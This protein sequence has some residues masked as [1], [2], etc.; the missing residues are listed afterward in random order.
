M[1]A[2]DKAVQQFGGLDVLVNNASAI[3]LTGK[4]SEFNITPSGPAMIGFLNF[5]YRGDYNEEV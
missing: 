5:R 2:M 3:S 4:S 1:K